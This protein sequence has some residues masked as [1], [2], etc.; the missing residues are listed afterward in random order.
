MNS[1]EE[2][3]PEKKRGS[4]LLKIYFSQ[5][6]LGTLLG[7]VVIVVLILGFSRYFST[8]SK[9]EKIGFEDIGELATQ[10]AYATEVNVTE[11]SRDLFGVSIPFTQSKYIYSYDVELKAG[12]DFGEIEWKLNDHRIEVSLPEAKVLSCEIDLDSLKVYHEEESIFRQVTLE[13]NNEALKTLKKN[14]ENDAVANG[15]LENARSNAETILTGFFGN[16]YNLDEYEII[17]KDK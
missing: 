4:R 2:K 16:V 15:F 10:S 13:E 3:A 9:T 12:F 17:F 8:E 7:L 14:A 5:K 6:I 11:A 1:Q